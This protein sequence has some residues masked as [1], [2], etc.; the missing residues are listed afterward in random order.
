MA[1]IKM[2]NGFINLNGV[3]VGKFDSKSIH[4]DTK[5]VKNL[6]LYQ[7]SIFI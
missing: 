3:R 6:K 4:L 1:R 7:M 5:V 2:K